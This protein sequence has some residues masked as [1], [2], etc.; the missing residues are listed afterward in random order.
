MEYIENTNEKTFRDYIRVLFRHKLLIFLT[1]IFVCATVFVGLKLKSQDYVA[2][3]KMI[4]TAEKQVQAPYYREMYGSSNVQQTLTQSVVVKS[5]PV[6]ERVVS[7]LA[8]DKRPLDDEKQFASLLRGVLIDFLN[9]RYLAKIHPLSVQQRNLL[10]FRQA[11]EKLRTN[12]TVKPIR[13]T[14]MFTIQVKDYNPVGAAI[15]AN[16]V[17]RAYVIFDLQQQLAELKLKYG[18]KHPTVKLIRDS[19]YLLQTTLQGEP[20]KDFDAL[21]PASVKIIEQA[22]VPLKQAGLSKNLTFLLAFFIS[23]FIA[24]MLAFIFEYNDQTFKTP[25][26]VE[27]TLGLPFLGSVPK[28]HLTEKLLITDFKAKKSYAHFNKILFEQIALLMNDKKSTTLLLTS[29]SEQEAITPIMINCAQYLSKKEGFRVLIIDANFRVPKLNKI[30]KIKNKELGLSDLLRGKASFE[31][32]RQA[33]YPRCDMISAGLTELNPVILLDSQKIDDIFAT[34]KKK[35]D[36][37]LIACPNLQGQKDA[38]VLSNHVDQ[39]VIVID[40]G[41]T[42]RLVIKNALQAF[43]THEKKPLGFI[44][45]NRTFP[46]PKFVYEYV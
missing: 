23:I 15:I 13:D 22:S 8:L 31:Q 38:I 2:E 39:T 21:G 33:L 14:N 3:V 27:G 4:I 26:E 29:A 30:L 24:I 6:I 44:L 12:I 42:R 11:V 25:Q 19:I 41:Q 28:R 16:V 32:V 45:S 1:I 40:E 10:A 5:N 43:K 20:M 18:E 9:A 46:I 36:I 35:Y 7:S 37:V 34:T 17:S